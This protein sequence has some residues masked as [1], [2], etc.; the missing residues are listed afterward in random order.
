MQLSIPGAA[1]SK[2]NLRQVYAVSGLN[3][4]A[5]FALQ[6]AALA[7]T[8]SALAAAAYYQRL[9]V[10]RKFEVASS[11]GPLLRLLDAGNLTANK[12]WTARD[13]VHR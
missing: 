9:D 11:T 12:A 6:N 4:F 2:P 13:C 1:C 10:Q 5:Y 7:S 8:V 3:T